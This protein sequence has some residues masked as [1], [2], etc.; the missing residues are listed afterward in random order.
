MLLLLSLLAIAEEEEAD[1]SLLTEACWKAPGAET[2][3]IEAEGAA[4]TA[5]PSEST[6]LAADADE[7]LLLRRAATLSGE[8][9]SE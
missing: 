9:F 1:A 4:A 2:C 6:A 5:R 3:V 8:G 7:L